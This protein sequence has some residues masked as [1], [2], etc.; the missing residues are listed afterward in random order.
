VCVWEG[1]KE[2]SY[3]IVKV[4]EEEVEEEVV[5]VSSSTD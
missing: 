1:R 4:V 5:V 3:A 2:R